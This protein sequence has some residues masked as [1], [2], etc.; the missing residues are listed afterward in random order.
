M[1]IM[2]GVICGN[3]QSTKPTTKWP[4]LHNGQMHC[5]QHLSMLDKH[6]LQK[7]KERMF[8]ELSHVS[9]HK[10]LTE[11]GSDGDECCE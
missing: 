2:I 1:S 6:L 5:Y 8:F 7:T 9:V 11:I 4:C 3:Q 10:R